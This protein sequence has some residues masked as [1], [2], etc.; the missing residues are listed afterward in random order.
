MFE[1]RILP[2][3]SDTDAI[4]HANNASYAVWFEEARRHIFK[5]FNPSLEMSKWNLI[6]RKIDIDFL[7]QGAWQTEI[8]IQTWVSDL[9]TTSFSLLHHA[10]QSGVHIATSNEV[11][12]C[13]DYQQSQ[14]MELS[15][16]IRHELEKHGQGDI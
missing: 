5:I 3:F 14:K 12:V 2:R 16:S 11:L 7:A 13:F 1:T 15:K 4:G 8:L 6:L 9:R 10:L